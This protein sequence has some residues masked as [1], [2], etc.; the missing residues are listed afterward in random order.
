MLVVS[1]P[2]GAGKT[3][4]TRRLMA[5]D[6]EISLSISVTTRE[7]RPGEVDGSDY[8]FISPDKF[9]VMR[10]GGEL[11]ESAE[12]FDHFYGT[13]RGPVE[14]ELEA[15]RDVL[16]D[17][18]WQ[19]AQQIRAA[20]PDDLLSLFILP[21]SG[22]ALYER[23]VQRAQDSHEVIGRR[24]EGAAREISHWDEYDFVIINDDLDEAY[25]E[26]CAVLKAGRLARHRRGRALQD[27]VAELDRQLKDVMGQA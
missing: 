25:A 4:L 2:S 8:H 5:Q 9:A 11:L 19:G 24:M 16:F 10:D 18:D 6:N 3:T 27:H 1:S 22:R 15:G 12:V 13:P 26:I 21:P 14:R 20:M 23:L 7:A 17:I